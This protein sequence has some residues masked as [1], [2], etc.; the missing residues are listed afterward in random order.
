MLGQRLV[1]TDLELY[2][3]TICFMLPRD[4]GPQ[5]H[6]SRTIAPPSDVCVKDGRAGTRTPLHMHIILFGIPPLGP[7]SSQGQA[8]TRHALDRVI[9]SH[10]VQATFDPQPQG[11]YATHL[12]P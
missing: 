5:A 9:R 10:K 7:L 12:R 4:L 3:L 6:V 1:V 11:G 2:S 8:P